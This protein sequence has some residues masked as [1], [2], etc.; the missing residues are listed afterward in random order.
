MSDN[1][2]LKF[3]DAPDDE[4]ADND[5]VPCTKC[6]ALIHMHTTR[7]PYCGIHFRGQA[8]EFDRAEADSSGRGNR[9][10]RWIARLVLAALALGALIAA[11]VALWE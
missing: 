7:C 5:K 10:I 11:M 2:T 8:F 6:G 1:D 4:G 9:A 3:G